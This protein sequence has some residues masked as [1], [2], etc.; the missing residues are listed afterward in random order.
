MYDIAIIGGGLVGCGVALDLAKL[1][2]EL[3]III[4]DQLPPEFSKQSI[5]DSRI[6][7]ITPKNYEHLLSLDIKP[8]LKRIT[9]VNSMDVRGNRQSQIK[10]NKSDIRG[11]YLAKIIESNNLHQALYARLKE[12]S[13]VKFTYIKIKELINQADKVDIISEDNQVLN[14]RLLVAADGANSFVRNKFNF[15]M[16]KIPYHQS[17]VVANFE[18]EYEHRGIAY[19][20]FLNDSILAYLPLPQ[21]H[22]SIVWSTDNPQFLLDI[23]ANELTDLVAKQGGHILGGLNLISKPLAF[24]LQMNLVSQLYLGRVILIG[25]AA[26]TLHPLA[27][28]GV[29]LGFGDAWELTKTIAKLDLS[30]L[31][32]AGLSR[33]NYK[34]IAQVRKMQMTCHLLHRLFHNR[35]SLIDKL[36]NTGLN[37][38]DNMQVLKKTLINSAINY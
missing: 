28:Q 37:W 18:C 23:N 20:W 11:E 22:I 5:F 36:R 3:N 12:Y 33:F 9:S 30:N 17:A 2:P 10:F 8:E 32:K 15:S 19:Q 21:R 38:V 26:H 27:G 14:A 31:D 6:Y 29:N 1:N 24:P 4:I 35:L 25:D 7:A 34:R 16:H 13:K